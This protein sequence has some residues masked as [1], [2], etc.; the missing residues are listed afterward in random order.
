MTHPFVP[1]PA[2]VLSGDEQVVGL[3]D[4]TVREFWS[5]A[6][7]DL[8]SNTLRGVLAEFIVTRAVGSG[9]VRR[10]EWDAYDVVTPSGVRVEV[11]AAAYLQGW[12][13]PR[14]SRISFSGLSARTLDGSVNAYAGDR[15]YN[16]DVYCFAVHTATSH[17]SFDV[18]DTSQ[19]RFYVATRAAVAG[20]GARSLGLAAVERIA[21]GPLMLDEL[22]FAIETAG[23]KC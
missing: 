7:S 22:A 11:K 10:V 15:D 3:G 2:P 14:L 4:A 20:T 6:M 5:W 21:E 1:P 8:R 19:W 13:Q 17:E 23:A 18:L 9:S 16:A 12:S